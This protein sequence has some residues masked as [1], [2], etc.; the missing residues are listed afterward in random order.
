MNNV[1]S[2]HKNCNCSDFTRYWVDME[3]QIIVCECGKTVDPIKAFILASNEMKALVDGVQFREEQLNRR[4]KSF[5]RS[6]LFGELEK[7]E[8]GGEMVPCCPNCERPFEFKGISVW[9]SKKLLD[10][11]NGMIPFA[12]NRH[13]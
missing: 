5:P 10:R 13:E 2:I 7:M 11:T 4:E 1:V 12:V 8:N 3:R 6:V 9:A